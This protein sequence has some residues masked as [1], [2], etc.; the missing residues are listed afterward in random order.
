MKFG[1]LFA[2][3]IL[4]ILISSCSNK[5]YV[6]QQNSIVSVRKE[7]QVVLQ[8]ENKEEEKTTSKK[9]V[10]Y[11]LFTEIIED[12]N[13]DGIDD[14][15]KILEYKGEYTE[16]NIDLKICINETEQLFHIKTLN[17]NCIDK[18]ELINLADGKKSIGLWL[19]PSSLYYANLWR[20]DYSYGLVVL[21]FSDN[22]IS[23]I[24][25]SNTLPYQAKDNYGIKYV[26]D[27]FIEF[28]DKVSQVYAKYNVITDESKKDLYYDR[29]SELKEYTSIETMEKQNFYNIEIKD[30]D[31]DKIDE[32]ICSKFIPGVYHRRVFGEIDYIFNFKNNKYVVKKLTLRHDKR[33]E[34]PEIKLKKYESNIQ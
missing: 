31:L 12:I 3:L 15:I 16:D 5:N 1:R 10:E 6:E 21:N 34:L 26:G 32:I 28:Y 23:K 4:S 18:V 25:D 27:G 7:G 33:L 22:Q 14:N 29:L 9:K 20:H 17:L 13:N 19:F 11:K 8:Q 24:F 2:L 30:I